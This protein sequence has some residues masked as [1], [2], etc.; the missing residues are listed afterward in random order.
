[1]VTASVMADALLAIC[2]ALRLAHSVHA[3]SGHALHHHVMLVHNNVEK[4]L[5]P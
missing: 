3:S 5:Q 2:C 4:Q 1:M